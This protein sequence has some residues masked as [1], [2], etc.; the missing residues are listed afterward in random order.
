M[1]KKAALGK[2][3]WWTVGHH[4]N[5]HGL[6]ISASKSTSYVYVIIYLERVSNTQ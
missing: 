5:T 3:N 6:F 1:Y 2:A 4:K